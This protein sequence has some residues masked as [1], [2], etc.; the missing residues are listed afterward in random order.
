[1]SSSTLAS[2]QTAMVTPAGLVELT[3][4]T[5]HSKGHVFHPTTLCLREPPLDTN[6]GGTIRSFSASFVFDIV[7]A[8]EAMGAG[9]SLALVVSPTKDLSSGVP[10]SYLGLLN[11]TQIFAVELDAHKVMPGSIQVYIATDPW[12]PRGAVAGCKSLESLT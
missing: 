3:N 1:M 2:L 11:D 6:G 8:A 5:A 12:C 4:G 9:H 7:S 10:T